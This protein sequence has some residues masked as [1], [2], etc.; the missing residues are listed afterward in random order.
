MRAEKCYRLDVQRW[1]GVAATMDV[2]FLV[3]N[4]SFAMNLKEERPY[5]NEGRKKT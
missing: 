2:E 1:K 3:Y 5:M 4:A